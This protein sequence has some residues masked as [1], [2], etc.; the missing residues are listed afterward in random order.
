VIKQAIPYSL[1]IL[2]INLPIS[3]VSTVI[4][5]AFY[6]KKLTPYVLTHVFS[7]SFLGGGFLLGFLYYELFRY[8]EYFFFYNLGFSK[9]RLVA[10]AY[11]MHFALLLPVIIICYYA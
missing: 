4:F 7:V 6:A 1:Q 9:L 3:V 10:M 8:R 11:L 5:I 2:R